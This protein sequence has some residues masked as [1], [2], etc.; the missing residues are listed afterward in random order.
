MEYSHHRSRVDG[1]LRWG[2][3]HINPFGVEGERQKDFGMR[4][5]FGGIE[6]SICGTCFSV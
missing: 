1:V 6:E 2:L 3:S 5:P 4:H